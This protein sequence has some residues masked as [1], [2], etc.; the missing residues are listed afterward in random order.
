M[1]NYMVGPYAGQICSGLLSHLATEWRK[2]TTGCDFSRK[3][4]ANCCDWRSFYYVFS[5]L[6]Y[7][8]FF[9]PSALMEKIENSYVGSFCIFK[10]L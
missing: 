2:S 1:A 5:D 6:K 10:E 9:A 3:Y 4:L 8:C 7:N